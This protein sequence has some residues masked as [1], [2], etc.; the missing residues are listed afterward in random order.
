MIETRWHWENTH[1]SFFITFSFGESPLDIMSRSFFE[2]KSQ[3]H[4]KLPAINFSMNPL[5]IHSVCKKPG[6]LSADLSTSL[7]KNT[8]WIR[9]E[10]TES[11]AWTWRGTYHWKEKS[12]HP[13]NVYAC[14]HT[15]AVPQ[16]QEDG[17]AGDHEEQVNTRSGGKATQAGRVKRNPEK[18]LNPVEFLS[19][20]AAPLGGVRSLW[21]ERGKTGTVRNKAS[22]SHDMFS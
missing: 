7:M 19:S 4:V 16:G 17:L 21:R 12:T 20:S 6:N 10:F 22:N 9:A 13:C 11:K 2:D 15:A 3:N 18:S 14:A 1:F 5:R 8:Q